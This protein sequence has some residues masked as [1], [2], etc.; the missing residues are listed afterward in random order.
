MLHFPLRT[1]R[2]DHDFGIRAIPPELSILE[3]TGSFDAEVVLKN[4]LLAEDPAN[5]FQ[6]LPESAP[7]CGEAAE[8]V[9]AL[10]D[11]NPARQERTREPCA[12]DDGNPLLSVARTI[13]EDL[14]VLSGD[15][16]SG[17]PII[18]GVVCFPSGWSI[19]DKIGKSITETHLPVPA[20]ASVLAEATNRLLIKLKVN[21]PVWR[22][23][24][25]VRCSDRLDQSPKHA[26]D[27]HQQLSLLN[28]GNIGKRCVFRVERQTLSRL[29][30]SGGILFTIHTH[31]CPLGALDVAERR[32]LLGV[33]RT[34]PDAT[35]RYKGI[36][37]M[38]DLVVSYLA[39]SLQDKMP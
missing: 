30:E 31:Q 5:Y 6:A 11:G 13:Q 33:I 8:L 28:S 21:R 32:K 39:D 4:R 19:A 27:L 16:Q 12:E 17:H 1:D 37:P 14:V 36:A 23:N 18:A 7:A 9:D 38:R 34:C 2:F 20:Y 26:H 24:W 10:V 35:L 22:T 29:P 3:R 15:H 25:G